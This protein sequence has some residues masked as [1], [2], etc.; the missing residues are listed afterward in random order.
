MQHKF[1]VNFGF[2]EKILKKSLKFQLKKMDQYG[3]IDCEENCDIPCNYPSPY[4]YQNCETPCNY[5]N[6]DVPC[7]APCCYQNSGCSCQS[8]VNPCFNGACCQMNSVCGM[9]GSNGTCYYD[10]PCIFGQGECKLLYL[11]FM[12]HLLTLF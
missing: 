8:C 6:C 10:T 9:V 5:Q 1:P 7:N 3:N 2:R 12:A 4:N 11:S